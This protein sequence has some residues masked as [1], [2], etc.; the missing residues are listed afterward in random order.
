MPPFA[1]PVVG[2]ILLPGGKTLMAG[3]E[4]GHIEFRKAP[5]G[6]VEKEWKWP[7]PAVL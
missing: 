3:D 6:E 1:R 5:T 2:A 7:G 4:T